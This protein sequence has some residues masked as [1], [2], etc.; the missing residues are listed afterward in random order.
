[1]LSQ[2]MKKIAA[3]FL[4]FIPIL[5]FSTNPPP[6]GLPDPPSVPVDS[7][8]F[9]LVTAAVVWGGYIVMK[10]KRSLL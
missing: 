10:R 9:V 4:F 6:P 7:M 5:V 2:I 3:Y 8:L 1:M